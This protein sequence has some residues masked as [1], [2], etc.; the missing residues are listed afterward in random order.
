M[1]AWPL[2]ALA[3][4]CAA[5]A[6]AQPFTCAPHQRSI[7]IVGEVQQGQTFEQPFGGVFV[8]RL[9]ASRDPGM[10]GWT[11]EIRRRGDTDPERELSWVVTLPYRGWSPRYIDTSYGKSAAEAVAIT[12]RE[13]EFLSDPRSEEHT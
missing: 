12:P 6:S 8:L 4:A 13:F 5:P 11:I 7:A 9:A 1:R 2:V 10:P 3:L